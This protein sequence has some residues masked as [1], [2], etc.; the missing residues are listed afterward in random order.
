MTALFARLRLPCLLVA[1]SVMSLAGCAGPS[2]LYVNPQA[3]QGYYKKVVVVPFA[4]VSGN[5]L[6]A[7]RVTEA[8]VSEL[9]IADAYQ[10]VEPELMTEALA[11]IGIEPDGTG[12]YPSD[13]VKDI[14][15]KMGVQGIIQGTVTEYEMQR[16]GEDDSPVLGFNAEMID[17]ATGNVVWRC[18][19]VGRGVGRVPIVGGGIRTLAQLTQH[20]CEDAVSD[21]KAHALR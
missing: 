13:K 16:R 5:V 7:P 11:N 1:A 6:S 19:W 3:D 2:R 17:L 20:A 9:I 15:T 21:L 18:H 8:F 4:T 10:V 14:A 12:R